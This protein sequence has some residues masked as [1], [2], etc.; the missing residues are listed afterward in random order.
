M[1]SFHGGVL[2]ATGAGCAY[3]G[4]GWNLNQ[5]PVAVTVGLGN[6]MARCVPSTQTPK[7]FVVADLLNQNQNQVGKAGLCHNS[8]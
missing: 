2:V 4:P 5:N 3:L 8:L 6:P 7:Q 1:A